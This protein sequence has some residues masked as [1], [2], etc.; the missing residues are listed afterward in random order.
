MISYVRGVLAARRPGHAVLDVGGLGFG[1]AVPDS[2]LS[3]LPAPGAEVTLLTILHVREDALQLFGFASE[4]E[5]ALFERLLTVTGV[6]PKLALAIL[7]G[8]PAASF[9]RAVADGSPRIL[10]AIPGVGK[11]LAERLVVELRDR[12]D[13][14]AGA[15]V[16]TSAEAQGDRAVR[17]EAVTGLV[18]LGLAR[19]AADDLVTAAGRAAPPEVTAEELIRRSLSALPGRA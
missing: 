17:E 12:V 2:T 13:G 19:A 6:G 1:I 15:A 4:M 9:L 7:S 5:R 10:T 11:R 18:L 16:A 14:L 3:T 8:M